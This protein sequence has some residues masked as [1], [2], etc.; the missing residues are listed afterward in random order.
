MKN[1]DFLFE[2]GTE[3][4]PPLKLAAFKESL[5]LSLKK[6][7]ETAGLS[8]KS[9]EGFVTPRRLAVMISELSSE[10]PVQH[11]ERKGP[12]VL[13]SFDAEKKPTPALLGFLNS[14][15][16]TEKECTIQSTPKGD[17]MVYAAKRPGAALFDLLPDLLETALKELPIPKRMKWGA[18]AHTFVRPV[19]WILALYGDKVLPLS[20]F[21]CA[22]NRI[23]Y[24]HRF[25]APNPIELKHP[26][27]YVAAL[28]KAFVIVDDNQRKASILSQIREKSKNLQAT[29]VISES[30][31]EEVTGLTEWPIAV[32][33]T[34]DDRFL[35]LPPE[36]PICSMQTHQRYFPLKNSEGALLST[37]IVISNTDARDLS[38]VQQGHER[39]VRARLSDA[40][41]FY[42]HDLKVPLKSHRERLDSIIFQNQLGSIGDKIKRLQK[43]SKHL[44]PLFN[45]NLALLEEVCELSKCDLLTQMV[46]EFPELQGTMGYYYALANKADKRIAL[47]IQEHFL[48]RFASDRLPSTPEGITLA[49]TDRMDTLYGI[50]AIGMLPT[51]TKDPYALRRQAIAIIRIIVEKEHALSLKALIDAAHHAYPSTLQ[52]PQT[53]ELLFNFFKERLKNWLLEAHAIPLDITDAVLAVTDEPHHLFCRAKALIEFKKRPEALALAAAHKRVHNI[54]AKLTI[55]PH[56]N[57]D[58]SHFELAVEQELYQRLEGIHGAL[59]YPKLLAQLAALQPVVD[60]FFEEVL[61]MSDKIE[62]RNNRLALLKKLHSAFCLIADLSHLQS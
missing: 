21:G 56:Q 2:I 23:S 50:F 42:E 44:A 45:A 53:T 35:K 48:P 3:E 52:N 49:I 34:F 55:E 61:V 6:G 22:A 8:F 19:H 11:I 17:F 7:L 5:V 59:D 47:A 9:I 1:D 24:G 41:Y 31:L 10:Q 26:Q 28:H 33:A 13:A 43:I 32:T 46:Y 20:L 14:L 62:V 39:V 54:L 58:P 38:V 12:N 27:D 30:V 51:G 18:Y 37:F 60:R 25:H 36:V 4:M 57:I 16:I 15:N 29:P 40:L